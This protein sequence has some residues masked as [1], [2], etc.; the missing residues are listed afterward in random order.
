MLE[1]LPSAIYDVWYQ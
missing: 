1:L